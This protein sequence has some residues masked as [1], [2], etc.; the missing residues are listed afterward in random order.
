MVALIVWSD[1]PSCYIH[2]YLE[3]SQTTYLARIQRL[4]MPNDLRKR[5]HRQNFHGFINV[6][7]PYFCN[8]SLAAPLYRHAYRK[9]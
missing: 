4:R 2:R 7:R 3:F 5:F 9:G 8:V 6:C 1:V